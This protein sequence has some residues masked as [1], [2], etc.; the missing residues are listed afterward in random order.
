MAD[1]HSKVPSDDYRSNYDAI[2]GRKS[3]KTDAGATK[4]KSEASLTIGAFGKDHIQFYSGGEA[5]M[6]ISNGSFVVRGKKVAQ[7]ENEAEVVYAAF[8]KWVGVNCGA[9]ES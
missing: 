4:S 3:P 2:L 8:K 7:D 9:S 6:E 1:I 5:V